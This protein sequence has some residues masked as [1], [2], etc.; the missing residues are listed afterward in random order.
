MIDVYHLAG[1]APIAMIGMFALWAAASKWHW[2]VRTVIVAAVVLATLLIPAH[3]LAYQ[4]GIESLLV[5]AGMAIWRRQR[6]RA[7]ESPPS[8][9]PRSWFSLSL[10]TLMLMVVV[11]AV[12]TAVIARTPPIEP[13]QWYD[14]IASGIMLAVICLACVWLA[15]GTARWWLRLLAAPLVV[16]ALAVAM[17]FLKWGAWIVRRWG[18]SINVISDFFEGALRDSSRGIV[19]WIVSIGL[20]MAVLCAWMLLMRFGGWF[21]PFRGTNKALVDT[22]IA[23]GRVALARLSTVILFCLASLFPVAFFYRLLTPTPIPK[24]ILPEPNG[25]DDF[26]A[27]GRMIGPTTAIKLS[28]WDQ[29]TQ[30]QLGAELEKNTEAFN[31]MRSGF[32]K[33]S[34]HP[35]VFNSWR[36]EDVVALRYLHE[37][38]RGKTAFARRSS[39]LEVELQNNLDLLRLAHAE[40]RGMAVRDFSGY[41]DA[42]EWDAHV[43]I[44]NLRNKLSAEQCKGLI[45]MLSDLDR[46]REPWSLRAERQRIIE[47]N[48]GWERHAALIL[49]EWSGTE[50]DDF[51]RI[52]HFKRV[53]ELRIVIIGLSLRAYQL[54]HGRL[55]AHLSQLVP[56]YLPAVP[57]DPFSDGDI[58]YRLAGASYDVYSIGSDGVDDD[59][60]LAYIQSLTYV[61]DFTPVALFG[62]QVVANQTATQNSDSESDR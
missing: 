33:K 24:V 44:W 40:S 46:R 57:Q 61:G 55:P 20:G 53:T 43:G 7:L 47:Q 28:A 2:F 5:V 12:A 34:L 50:H 18:T 4:L 37:A 51:S 52:E 54:D 21:D 27:A 39:D 41:I 48:K 8:H 42:F 45:A 22:P 23:K 9:T 26:V 10:E 13:Y 17:H 35:Y 60:R 62:E 32:Q 49:E 1:A 29:L 6:V 25:F 58:K 19:F 36:Q 3:V 16:V 56:G 15:C 30:E 59:G 11:V 31:R 14:L 38:L